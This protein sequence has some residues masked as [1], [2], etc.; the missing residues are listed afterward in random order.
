MSFAL[1]L[2]DFEEL[3]FP[4][5]TIKQASEASTRHSL[6]P[7]D[8]FEMIVATCGPKDRAMPLITPRNFDNVAVL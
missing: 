6:K 2:I 1:F 8:T 4:P 3:V 7:L 5:A